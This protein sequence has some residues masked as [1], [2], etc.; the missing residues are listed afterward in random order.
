M[1]TT[2]TSLGPLVQ[3]DGRWLVGDHQRPGGVW[4]EFRTDGLCLH[5]ADAEEQVTPWARIM[6]LNR[7]TL[8]GRYPRGSYGM[9]ALLGGWRGPWQGRGRGYLHMTLRHPY[10]DWLAPFDRHPRPYGFTELALFEA[11]L[12]RT[13]SSGEVHRLGDGEWLG[14]AVRLLAGQRPRTARG[15][16]DAVTAALQA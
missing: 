13:G 10:E 16:R 4:L 14:R 5:T 9:L 6:D 7:F 8:G 2:H 1:S 3:V 15:I 12:L 11:L